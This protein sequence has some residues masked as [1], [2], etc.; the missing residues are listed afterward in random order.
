MTKRIRLAIAT[1]VIAAAG[2]ACVPVTQPA[3]EKPQGDCG[4]QDVTCQST[5]CRPG[6]GVAPCDCPTLPA[7]A[8]CNGSGYYP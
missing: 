3:P 6:G 2:A 7:G 1:L 4:T 8:D 5:D